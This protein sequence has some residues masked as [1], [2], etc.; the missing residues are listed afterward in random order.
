MVRT[1]STAGAVGREL[2]VCQPWWGGC[3]QSPRACVL[4]LQGA[5]SPQRCWSPRHPGLCCSQ[6]PK[7]PTRP[8][9]EPLPQVACATPPE[10]HC[11]G[12]LRAASSQPFLLCCPRASCRPRL[13]SSSTFV[14]DICCVAS[15]KLLRL[16]ELLSLPAQWGCRW[17]RPCPAG[18]LFTREA[19]PGQQPA[20]LRPAV[21]PGRP[22]GLGYLPLTP[23]PAFVLRLLLCSGLSLLGF[24]E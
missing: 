13:V 20:D 2:G 1:E 16:S 23:P 18:S 4:G 22:G 10:N 9:L 24:E 5:S 14:R 19:S 15:A 11:P 12:A 6:R 21:T 3:S 17:L 7:L 8:R